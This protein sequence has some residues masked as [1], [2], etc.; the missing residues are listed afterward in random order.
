MILFFTGTGNS[1]YVAKAIANKI[2][3]EVVS[4]NNVIKY[5]MA[6]TFRSD[7][8][9]II[10]API[11]AWRFPAII[12]DLINKAEFIGNNEIYFIGT[13]ESQSGNC[14][15]YCKKICDKKGLIF[16][17]FYGVKMPGNYVISKAMPDKDKVNE[18]LNAANPVIEKLAEKI[19][20]DENIEKDDK[21]PF[22][23]VLSSAVNGAFNKF[24]VSS[25]NFVVSDR[26]ITCGK[27]EKCC[28]VN[29]VKIRDG[30]PKFGDKCINCYSCIHHCPKEAINIKG[31]SENHGRYLCPEY[32]EK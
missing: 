25:K 23:W 15:K 13:M 11:Y 32:N 20:N 7:K 30:K 2:N 28:P 24:M 3:D 6:K 29:N 4:L 26:C 22:S 31:K 19:K 1:K 12:E 17:G 8:P 21:T 27:C 14:Y 18:I 5:T 10:V 9:F 16:K